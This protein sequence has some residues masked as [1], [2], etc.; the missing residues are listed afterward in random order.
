MTIEQFN[1][2]YDLRKEIEETKYVIGI[3]KKHN[4][5]TLKFVKFYRINNKHASKEEVELEIKNWINELE[6]E[7]LD[8]E[9]QFKEL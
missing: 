7:L 9:K 8:L 1:M 5:S 6:D 3:L 2:A 4:R